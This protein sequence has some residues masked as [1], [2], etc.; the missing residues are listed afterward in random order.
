MTNYFENR[1]MLKTRDFVIFVM[2]IFPKM[3]STYQHFSSSSHIPEECPSTL[4]PAEQA[5]CPRVHRI[6]ASVTQTRLKQID[7][8]IAN[9]FILF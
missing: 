1:I 8:K 2:T 5:H 9:L 6:P 3:I 4:H 7:S